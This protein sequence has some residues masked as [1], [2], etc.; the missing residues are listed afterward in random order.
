MTCSMITATV[1]APTRKGKTTMKFT[2]TQRKRVSELLAKPNESLENLLGDIESL[3]TTFEVERDRFILFAWHPQHKVAQAV[4]PYATENQA[5]KDAV[6][7]I[8]QS[9]GTQVR[10]V[11]LVEPSTI[12]TGL[13]QQSLM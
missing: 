2:P 5:R 8:V 13:G 1:A 11:K 4:G 3:I 6:N 10:V 12:D 7:R 9:G